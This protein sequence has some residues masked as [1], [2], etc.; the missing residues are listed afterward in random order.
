MAGSVLI[1]DDEPSV[2]EVVRAY[3]ERDGFTVWSAENGRDGL[4]LAM[5]AAPSLIILDLMLPDLTGE[6]VCR[7][8]R[9]R[10]DV[11]IVMLTAKADEEERLAGLAIGA[12]DYLV[13]PFSP[14]ELVARIRA[15]L[16]RARTLDVPLVERIEL[17]QRRLVIDTVERSVERDG[18]NVDLTPREYQLLVTLARFPGRVY[19]RYELLNALQGQNAAGDERIV[20]VH[21]KNL[22]KKIEPNPKRPRYVLTVFGIGYRLNKE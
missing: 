4:A 2:R 7:Q 15:V 3:L 13:K 12:D 9:R 18:H 8:L 19:S 5:R 1:I 22:R 21:V 16:R 10:S 20:D 14:R 6:D 11:P 17:D